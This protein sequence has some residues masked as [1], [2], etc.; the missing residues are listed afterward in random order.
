MTVLAKYA[1]TYLIAKFAR[2][3]RGVTM[4]EYSILLG[5]ITVAAITAIVFAG[6]WVGQQWDSLQTTLTPAAPATP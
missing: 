6:G 2:D 3:E 5:I 1:T 4:L